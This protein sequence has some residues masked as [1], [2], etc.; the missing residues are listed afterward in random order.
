MRNLLN[1]LGN[2]FGVHYDHVPPIEVVQNNFGPRIV[3]LE[4]FNQLQRQLVDD[5]YRKECSSFE[6]CE[7]CINCIHQFVQNADQHGIDRTSRLN[8]LARIENAQQALRMYSNQYSFCF[9][10]FK[11]GKGSPNCFI[12]AIL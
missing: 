8:L 7:N 10:I 1:T 5:E 6:E 12:N 11:I 9:I 4:E 3:G 2:G